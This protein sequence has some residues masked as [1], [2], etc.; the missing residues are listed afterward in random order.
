MFKIIVNSSDKVKQYFSQHGMT[1]AEFFRP[2]GS[3]KDKG[4]NIKIKIVSKEKIVISFNYIL[5]IVGKF[6]N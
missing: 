6:K 4:R 3:F 1:P 5:F 2:F